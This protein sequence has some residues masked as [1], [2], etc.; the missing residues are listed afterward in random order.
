MI[1]PPAIHQPMA[2][3]HGGYTQVSP[4]RTR[5][6]VGLGSKWN[7]ALYASI[8]CTARCGCGCG[9]GR[10]EIPALFDG[11]GRIVWVEWY[12]S[13]SK[14]YLP[15]AP[16]LKYAIKY[17]VYSTLKSKSPLFYRCHLGRFAFSLVNQL[18]SH[19][20]N[21]ASHLMVEPDFLLLVYTLKLVSPLFI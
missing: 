18:S 19:R 14:I 12:F 20:G 5:V 8:T 1:G 10:G 2:V 16:K 15:A 6:V 11:V 21:K 3:A 13:H 7:S 4:A 17:A 9:W